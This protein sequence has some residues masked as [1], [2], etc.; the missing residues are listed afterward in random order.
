MNDHGVVL[1]FFFFSPPIDMLAF[2]IHDKIMIWFENCRDD[3]VSK[4]YERRWEEN[5]ANNLSPP[6]C[7][8]HEIQ[9]SFGISVLCCGPCD[10]LWKKANETTWG[11]E[12][13]HPCL[14]T[15]LIEHFFSLFSDIILI[16]EKAD[17]KIRVTLGF[18]GC[19]DWVITTNLDWER[20]NIAIGVSVVFKGDK[21]LRDSICNLECAITWSHCKNIENFIAE[22]SCE[23]IISLLGCYKALCDVNNS[24]AVISFNDPSVGRG[25]AGGTNTQ[26]LLNTNSIKPESR[27]FEF[28]DHISVVKV[29]KLLRKRTYQQECFWDKIKFHYKLLKFWIGGVLGFWGFVRLQTSR[30]SLL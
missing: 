12:S 1:V 26:V 4:I 10:S 6:L 28:S 15:H 29:I 2:F 3:S 16:L 13:A 30:I 20:D 18:C 23:L 24:S 7:D 8:R 25:W 27:L 9:S 14:K 21:V 17:F 19:I 11:S 22:I 5:P